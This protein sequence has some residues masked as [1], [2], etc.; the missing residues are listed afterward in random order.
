M[1]ILSSYCRKAGNMQPSPLHAQLHKIEVTAGDT[2]ARQLCVTRI[3]VGGGALRSTVNL[4]IQ[5]SHKRNVLD[6]EDAVFD[7]VLATDSHAL[8]LRSSTHVV[9]AWLSLSGG[10]KQVR[11]LIR[12]CRQGSMVGL[13]GARM[14]VPDTKLSWGR[15]SCTAECAIR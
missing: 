11:F 6:C 8:R 4:T 5:S 12:N 1:P 2:N 7:S 9:D 15:Q 14:Q 3:R 13:S 10:I